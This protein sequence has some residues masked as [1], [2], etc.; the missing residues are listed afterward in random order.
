MHD[1]GPLRE[2]G[3][4]HILE[5]EDI[6]HFLV[7]TLAVVGAGHVIDRLDV[8][9]LYHGGGAHV[10]EQ[11]DLAALVQRD[12]TVGTAEQYV[13]LDADRAQLLHRMLGGL[14]LEFARR[15]DEG[16]Q[17]EMDVEA[18]PARLLLAELADRLE[19]GQALDV[20]HRAADLDQHEIIALVA[21]ADELLDG[22]R[23]MRD[24]LYR[25]AKEIAAPFLGDDFLVDAPRRDV[26]LAVGV[27]AGEALVMT[28]IEV[29]LRTV[30]GHE[31]LAVLIG[32]HRAR[33]DVQV[34]VEL[35]QPDGKAPRLQ[36][37]T[38]RRRCQPLAERGNHAAGDE[39]ISRHGISPYRLH[40]MI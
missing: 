39:N 6:Q 33:I 23:H 10:A 19:E 14:G 37:S 36:Q 8:E 18:I 12:F 34:G 21:G 15:G 32:A 1:L 16:Q 11:R 3:L 25:A 13:G 30:V 7:E 38:E 26:V 5:A 17:G 24:H 2:V 27:A 9:R 4:L 28:K 40:V 35:A 29:G 20:A 22:V 31:D